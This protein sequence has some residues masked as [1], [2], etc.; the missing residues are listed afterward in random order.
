MK[1]QIRLVACDLD[2]TLLNNGFLV[3]ERNR[4][5]IR[6]VTSQGVRFVVLTGRV[7]AA[8]WPIVRSLDLKL[9]F[10]SFQGGRITDPV[11]E[12]VLHAAELDKKK[13]VDI[14]AYAE[15]KDIH[16]NIYDEHQIFVKARNEWT[17]FYE[18]FARRVPVQEVGSLVGFPFQKTAKM[19]LIAD[20]EKLK[21][22]ARDIEAFKDPL[23]NM[24]FSKKHFLEFT[25][26]NATKGFALKWLAEKWKIPREE[27]MAIGDNYNDLSMIT[28]AGVG[29]CME[30]GEEGVKQKSDFVT[31]SNESDGV[32]DALEKFVYK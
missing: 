9:P 28:F 13:I 24:F 7:T 23:V 25:D 22:A 18:N 1:N 29:V 30:N 11:T 4:A 21:K 5:A 17:D 19:V 26:Q 6:R 10:G 15:K 27:T 20:H 3:S 8:T 2:D 12:E 32:A 16:V 31:S 14:L